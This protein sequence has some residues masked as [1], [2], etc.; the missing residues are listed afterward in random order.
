MPSVNF[1]IASGWSPE[2]V[3]DDLRLKGIIKIADMQFNNC[4]YEKVDA[5]NLSKLIHFPVEV[6]AIVRQYRFILFLH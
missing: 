4:A 1:L 3:Y 6:T 2:G 5:F